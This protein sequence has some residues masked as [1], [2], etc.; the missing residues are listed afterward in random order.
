MPCVRL[1]RGS[2]SAGAQSVLPAP[3]RQRKELHGAILLALLRPP[4]MGTAGTGQTPLQISQHPQIP[5]LT[6]LWGQQ[7]QQQEAA[8]SQSACPPGT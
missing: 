5:L 1:A 2:V 4:G 6:G 3:G 8:R 7:L